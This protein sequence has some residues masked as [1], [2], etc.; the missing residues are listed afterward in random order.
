MPSILQRLAYQ[1]KSTDV[2]KM[3]FLNHTI[4]LFIVSFFLLGIFVNDV[5]AKTTSEFR[6]NSIVHIH[7]VRQYMLVAYRMA[8]QRFPNLTPEIIEAYSVHH[9]WP[10]IQSLVTLKQYGYKD[11]TAIAAIL[12]RFDEKDFND[13]NNDDRATALHARDELNRIE[14]V[15]KNEKFFKKL[16][17]TLPPEKVENIRKQLHTLEI[18]VD[19]TITCMFR[20]IELHI[21]KQGHYLGAKHLAERLHVP[22]WEIILSADLEDHILGIVHTC[23]AHKC[24]EILVH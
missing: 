4:Q 18:I 5:S 17:E 9:D 8:P 20:R 16:S 10:K 19:W 3:K 23:R 6:A 22:E 15:R 1:P 7:Q 14:D 2:L 13:L 21:N 24:G 11:D 12:A